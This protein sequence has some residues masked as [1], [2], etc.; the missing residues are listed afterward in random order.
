MATL[1]N[2]VL[3]RYIEQ[4]D[5]LRQEALGLV[6]GLTDA[7]FNWKPDPSSWS[8]GQCLQHVTMTVLLYPAKIEAMI[9]EARDRVQRGLRPYREGAFTRW[10]V[11]S[12]EPPPMLRVRTLRKVQPPSMLERDRVLRDFEEAHARLSELVAAAD[13]V[14]LKHGRT[15]SPFFPLLRFTLDQVLA[16]NLAHGRR[17]L[18]QARQILQSPRF[19]G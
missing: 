13:G 9:V 12:M 16:L 11:R 3:N 1:A 5:T 17:H 19:P 2:A 15:A 18:W 4:L 14:S 7:Q 8:V 10:F 6:D